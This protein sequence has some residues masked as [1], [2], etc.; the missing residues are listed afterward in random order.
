MTG[1]PQQLHPFRALGI[2]HLGLFHLAGVRSACL[3]HLHH[4]TSRIKASQIRAPL[5]IGKKSYIEVYRDIRV[6]GLPVTPIW[7][8]PISSRVTTAR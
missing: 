7:V 1:L 3:K 2:W 4:L 8:I 5:K 6:Y